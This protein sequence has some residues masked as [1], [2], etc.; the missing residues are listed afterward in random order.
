MSERAFGRMTVEEFLRWDDGTDT[1]YE[2]IDGVPVAMAPP[3]EAHRILMT[4]LL[5]GIDARLAGRRPCNA[6]PEAG[7][8][9]ADRNSYFEADIAVTCQ[10]N[11][12][13]RQAIAE[14]ILVVEIL[15]P[16]TEHHDR[17]TKLPAYRQIPSVEEVLLIDS[18]EAYAE[19]H[20][21][22]GDHWI[23]E[24]VQ[25]LSAKLRLASVDLEIGMAE[26]YDG[27]DIA[28]AV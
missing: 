12:R 3:A 13:G 14:P 20:R 2:L 16:G 5:S 23:T 26:L 1:H 18:Q 9:R 27:L 7:G 21:K 19:I 6:Q 8:L 28:E 10:P 24:L 25:G 17:Q 11:E 22:S 15:S 4:R